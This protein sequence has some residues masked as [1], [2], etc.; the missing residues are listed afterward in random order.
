MQLFNMADTV[1]HRLTPTLRGVVM[2]VSTFSPELERRTEYM[3]QY[4]NTQGMPAY[5]W[6]LGR[7]LVKVD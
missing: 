3:V 1:A 6:F 7:D 4:V 5:D 2:G